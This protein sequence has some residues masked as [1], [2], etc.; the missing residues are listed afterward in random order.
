MHKSNLLLWGR[1]TLFVFLLKSINTSSQN[2]NVQ[3]ITNVERSID[4]ISLLD[5]SKYFIIHSSGDDIEHLS[6]YQDYNVS[7]SG[8][9]FYGPGAVAKTASGVT[10]VYPEANL[11]DHHN[12]WLTDDQWYIDI[13][14]ETIFTTT[15]W[16]KAVWKQGFVLTP[17]DSLLI[18]TDFTINGTIDGIGGAIQSFGIQDASYGEANANQCYLRSQRKGRSVFSIGDNNNIALETAVALRQV[19]IGEDLLNIQIQLKL[20]TTAENSK[21]SIRLIN[22]S[23]GDISNW[24]SYTGIDQNLYN[25]ATTTGIYFFMKSQDLNALG[26]SSIE[27]SKIVVDG[28]QSDLSV[29]HELITEPLAVSKVVITDHPSSVYKEGINGDDFADWAVRYFTHHADVSLR[30]LWYEPMNE[31][32]V[33]ARDFYQEPDWDPIAEARVKGEMAQVIK[34]IGEKIDAEPALS[35]MKVIGFESAWPSFELQNF[36]NWELNMKMFLDVAGDYID[37]ISYHLYDGINQSGQDNKRSGSN[38]EAIMDLIETYS[39]AK[40]GAIKPHVV[41]EYGGDWRSCI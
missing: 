11:L 34:T 36:S 3:V 23:N 31:P 22:L 18:E 7:P 35:A 5:R 2:T 6:F 39:F 38:S 19:S 33:Y 9:K 4:G 15:S 40:W 20:G 27:F 13:A 17:G 32:F 25:A 29:L 8:R 10:G 37:A 14:R 28:L 21:L 24:G 41:T 30:P 12:D 1:M 16:K 26:F